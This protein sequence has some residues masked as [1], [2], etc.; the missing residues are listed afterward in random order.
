MKLLF[1]ALL[2][3]VATQAFAGGVK[4]Q[5]DNSCPGMDKIPT[6]DRPYIPPEA[7]VEKTKQFVYEQT[8]AKCEVN[9]G[10]YFSLRPETKRN[11]YVWAVEYELCTY[12]DAVVKTD[13]QC[14]II[15]FEVQYN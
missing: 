15:S 12:F 6:Q 11:V 8:Q 13:D 9:Y 1:I 5:L 4:C 14:N 10:G 7:C 3:V 2:T